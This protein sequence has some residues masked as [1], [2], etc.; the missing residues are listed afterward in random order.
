ML[1]LA[2]SGPGDRVT[3][4]RRN[5]DQVSIEAITATE[6]ASGAEGLATQTDKN[7]AGIAVAA[8]W[9]DHDPGYGVS[10]NLEKGIPLGSG[11]GSSATSAVAGV[12][13][14]NALLPEPLPISELMPYALEGELFASEGL[15]AD[16]VAASLFG[17]L[18]LCPEHL[19]PEVVALPVPTNLRSVLVHPALTLNTRDARRALSPMC[20]LHSAVEQQGCMAAFVA[21][22]YRDDW[23]LIATSFH[24]ILIEPQR[25]PLVK[26]FSDVQAAA[27]S[28]GAIGCSLSGSGPS[29]FAW[30][31]TDAAVA[32]RDAMVSAFAGHSLA[33]DAWISQLDAP[34]A[35]LVEG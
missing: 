5:D 22:C 24:D 32:V 16:N 29:L 2:I 30:A 28:A 18:V 3:A 1:G 12:V 10:L 34:G 6:L 26:G 4:S 25:A 20:A 7:T 9:R 14:A 27:L 13:A 33:A 17:G 19:L 23:D 15:H 8:L 35:H 21:G 31:A 11:M